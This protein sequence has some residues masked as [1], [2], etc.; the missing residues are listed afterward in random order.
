MFL[1]RLFQ[2][3]VVGHRVVFCGSWGVNVEIVESWHLE[4][5]SRA[6]RLCGSSSATKLKLEEIRGVVLQSKCS[7]MEN[8][9]PIV[10]VLVLL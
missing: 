2:M 10:A 4:L 9:K 3:Q 5:T 1:V 8:R 7:N 6:L